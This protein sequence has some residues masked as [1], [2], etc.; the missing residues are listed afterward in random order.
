M[1]IRYYKFFPFFSFFREI[2][3][4][5]ILDNLLSRMEQYANNLESLVEE[6]TADYLEEKR[7]AENLLYQLLPKSVASQLIHGKSVTAEA[8]DGV[9]IYFSDIVGFT[10]LS[11]QS[12]PMQVTVER[13]SS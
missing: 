5:N 12:T 2:E 4:G 3:S 9:T 7:K 10:S 13:I 1:S 11:A 8:F 6:R